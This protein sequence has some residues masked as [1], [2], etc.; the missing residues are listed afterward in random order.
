MSIAFEGALWPHAEALTLAAIL[1]AACVTDLRTR[2]IP[3]G[4]VLTGLLAGMSFALMDGG[5]G[6]LLRATEGAAT[7]LLIWLPFWLLH[8]MGGGDVKLFAAGAAWLGPSGAVEAAMLAGLCGGVL[9]LLYVLNR[10]GLT[11]TMFRLAYGMQHP[12]LLREAAPSEWNRRMPYALAM[13]AG[14][15]GAAYWPG[16]LL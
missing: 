9:S 10:Y 11:H 14:L 2:R 8:M 7:G 4:L 6:G 3:N 12:T 1:I 15:A 16:L 13:A 5:A